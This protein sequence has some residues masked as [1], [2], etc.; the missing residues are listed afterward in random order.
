MLTMSIPE[1]RVETRKVEDAIWARQ[2]A[3]EKRFC[4]DEELLEVWFSSESIK[5]VFLTY[6][7]GTWTD[8]FPLEELNEFLRE[9]PI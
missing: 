6:E 7:G 9:N 2:Q 1:W 3:F 8:S 4:H 5:V